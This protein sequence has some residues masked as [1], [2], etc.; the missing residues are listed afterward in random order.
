MS[1]SAPPRNY[2]KFL[3]S[4]FTLESSCNSTLPQLLLLLCG[5]CVQVVVKHNH[6]CQFVV[7]VSSLQERVDQPKPRHRLCTS[8]HHMRCSSSS[9]STSSS[10]SCCCWQCSHRTGHTL[11]Y[12]ANCQNNKDLN[13]K[14]KDLTLKTKAKDKTLSRDHSQKSNMF[15]RA[16]A[17]L[18]RCT[19][20]RQCMFITFWVIQPTNRQSDSVSS[21]GESEPT[22]TEYRQTLLYHWIITMQLPILWVQQENLSS[23]YSVL[24]I[25]HKVTN[26]IKWW[27]NDDSVYQK[28]VDI[29][30][31]LLELLTM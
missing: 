20:C 18:R 10:S 4:R 23:R 12:V 31:G 13:Y 21:G 19:N 24:N 25:S 6:L 30:P 15:L 11:R 2:T 7:L 29:E 5:V 14:A 1:N 17:T 22:P 8:Q 9:S 28:F 16:R 3:A 27:F 26:A